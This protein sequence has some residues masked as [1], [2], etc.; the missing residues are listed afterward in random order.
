MFFSEGLACGLSFVFQPHFYCPTVIHWELSDFRPIGSVF[1][2]V[3]FS[4]AVGHFNNVTY[5]M[6]SLPTKGNA[7]WVISI[8]EMEGNY[9]PSPSNWANVTQH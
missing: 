7:S 2:S 6:K 9:V 5:G 4:L 3:V 1:D 8:I